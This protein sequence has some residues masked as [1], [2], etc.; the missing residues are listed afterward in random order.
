MAK[1]TIR[2]VNVEGKRVLVRVDFNVPLD[3]KTGAIADDSR[4]RAALPTIKYL[5]E[6]KAKVILCSHLGRPEGKVIEELRMAPIAQ[7]LSQLLNLPVLTAPNSIGSE[8]ETLV[9]QMKEGDILLLEN[10]RFH[11]EEEKNDPAFAQ[12]LARLADIYVN[13]AFG[14]AHRA[15]AS[16]VGIAKFLPAVAGFLM[17]KELT[18]MEKILSNPER[19][20]CS[21]IGGAKVSDKIGL[22]ENIIDKVD[23]LLIG[24]GMAATFLKAKGY[25][26]GR[27]VV[28]EDRLDK[29]RS[30]MEKAA[31]KGIIFLLPEDVIIADKIE[32]GAITKTV[33][34]AKIALDYYIV[35]IGPQTIKLFF[36]E[37]RKCRTILWN[38]PLGIYEIT[39]FASGT[40]T[41][42]N[43]LAELKATTIVGGGS[44][45][46]VVTE[47]GLAG[48]MTHVSTGGGAT[49]KFLEGK[50]LPGV[51]VLLDKN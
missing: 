31:K 10:L 8:V 41:I 17:E 47:M 48:K 23:S 6:N 15:H 2:D 45:A 7:R 35:D 24:G 43:F 33:S 1:R 44:T 50:I 18:V 49:L 3:P 21:L 36:T 30:L 29:A 46:E 40:K 5:V 26:V 19:P 39:P 28:E 51:A 9:G 34:V 11:A 13:D 42:A 16:T 37:L 20:F 14:T 4:I 12:G 27:S 32:A 38:G 22:L 25:K